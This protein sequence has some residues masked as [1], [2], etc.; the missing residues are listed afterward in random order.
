M[1]GKAGIADQVPV[2]VVVN[3]M[4]VCAMDVAGQDKYKVFHMGTSHRNPIT[5]WEEKFIIPPYC[6]VPNFLCFFLC[7]VTFNWIN[8]SNII[9]FYIIKVTYPQK[10]N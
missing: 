9:F 7:V 3:S 8:F 1:Y 10:S 4:L 2:D 5:W 6:R